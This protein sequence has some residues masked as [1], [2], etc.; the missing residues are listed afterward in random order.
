MAQW[1]SGHSLGAQGVLRY[2]GAD[3]TPRSEDRPRRESDPA[4]GFRRY[5]DTLRRIRVNES[6]ESKYGGTR[7]PVRRLHFDVLLLL[8]R[9]LH[10]KI[11]CRHRLVAGHEALAEVA[12]EVI[13]GRVRFGLNDMTDG[14]RGAAQPRLSLERNASARFE[15]HRRPAARERRGRAGGH[16][17]HHVHR[18]QGAGRRGRVRHAVGRHLRLRTPRRVGMRRVPP[19]DRTDSRGD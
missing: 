13:I 18:I 4:S 11:D 6:P 14:P 9:S 2:R 19:A 3:T 1:P 5:P 10:Q 7:C 16:G 15:C 12:G 17:R 8:K